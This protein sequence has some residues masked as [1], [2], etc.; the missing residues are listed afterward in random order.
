M[1]GGIRPAVPRGVNG[2]GLLERIRIVCVLCAAAML[3]QFYRAA[4]SVLA[5]PVMGDLGLEPAAYG[6]MT[7]VFFLAF[8]VMQVPAG[9]LFDR[10]GPRLTVSGLLLFAVVGALVFALGDSLLVLMLARILLGVGFASVIM[11]AFIVISAW[12]PPRHFAVVSS[13]IVSTSH[14][15]NLLG[16]AP[17]AYS[18]EAIGWRAS[19]AVLAVVTLLVAVLFYLLVRDGPQSHRGQARPAPSWRDLGQGLMEVLRM[20]DIQRAFTLAL[21]GYPSMITILGL[22]GGPY[23]SDVHGLDSV[24]VGQVLSAMPAFALVG[25]LCFGPLDQLFNS[26]KMAALSGIL[27]MGLFLLVLG[28]YPEPPLMLVVVLLA[29]IA[30]FS[31]SSMLIIAHGRGLL[32]DHLAGRGI[33]SINAGV[34]GG[35]ALFQLVTSFLLSFFV[36]AD[37]TISESGFRLMFIG[38]GGLVLLAILVYLPSRDVR[39]R[40]ARS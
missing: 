24:G 10:Y 4:N 6:T 12:F 19:I 11:G 40:S 1:N 21:V 13:I 9:V 34:M 8:M 26:R 18:T 22:W 16:T 29:A 20:R 14:L 25:A 38:M 17:L 32:P 2:R 5:G 33:T 23:L 3:S 15:G 28:V 36:G 7:A 37:G 27:P 39:P 30:F 35:T 31:A